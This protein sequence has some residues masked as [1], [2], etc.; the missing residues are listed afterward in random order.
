MTRKPLTKD[1]VIAEIEKDNIDNV[2]GDIT[3]FICSMN[4]CPKCGSTELNIKP[5]DCYAGGK[6]YD[7]TFRCQRCH[8]D[9][10]VS[11]RERYDV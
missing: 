7:P 2:E 11:I 1:E 6:S 8:R 9:Y 5:E 4:L 10:K 3:L